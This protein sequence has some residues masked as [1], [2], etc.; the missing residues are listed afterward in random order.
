MRP[1]DLFRG[2]FT[3]VFDLFGGG[4]FTAVFCRR[5]DSICITS[6]L[7]GLASTHNLICTPRREMFQ[8][9]FGLQRVPQCMHTS[10]FMRLSAPCLSLSS[11]RAANSA[12]ASTIEGQN[13]SRTN[14]SSLSLRKHTSSETRQKGVGKHLRSLRCW[15]RV[16]T[17]V[18]VHQRTS[19]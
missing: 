18:L 14:V 12:S 13:H 7:V 9:L 15:H 5:A 6:P 17:H 11:I 8:S 19:K 3:V 16:H 4:F 1:S 2:F 10:S